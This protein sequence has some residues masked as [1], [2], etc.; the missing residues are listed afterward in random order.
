MRQLA[1]PRSY[2][3]NNKNHCAADDYADDDKLIENDSDK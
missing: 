2:W 1:C 3:Y